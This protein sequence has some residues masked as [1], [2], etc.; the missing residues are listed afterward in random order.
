[1]ISQMEPQRYNN[2]VWS[3]IGPLVNGRPR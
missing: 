2:G 1:V 3:K